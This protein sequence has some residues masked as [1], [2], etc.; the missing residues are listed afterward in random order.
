M[1]EILLYGI[2]NCGRSD[3]GLG[4][5]FLDRVQ[6]QTQFRGRV[7]YRYQLQVEDAALVN[8]ANR[9]I[10]VDSYRG[11]LP[12]GFAW[13]PCNPAG[14]FDFTSHILAP[15]AVMHLCHMLYGRPPPAEQLLIQGDC[16]ALNTGMSAA[17]QK[18]LEEALVS[19]G[20][21]LIGTCRHVH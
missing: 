17:A 8:R 1:S 18:R 2:G 21:H 5:A 14:N 10:F 19:F 12:G 4:W 16:W 9:V 15:S 20:D 6:Q 7:E 3:D 13:K 11:E